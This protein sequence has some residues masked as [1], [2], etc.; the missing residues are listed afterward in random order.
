MNNWL[1]AIL[2][3]VFLVIVLIRL[4]TVPRKY[5]SRHCQGKLWKVN[6]PNTENE[7]IRSF[8]DCFIYGMAFFEKERLK[9]NPDDK[10]LDAYLSIY[11]GK[12]L[13][14][15]GDNLELESFMQ[16]LADEFPLGYSSIQDFW[17]ERDG[18]TLGE[19][20]HYV[21]AQKDV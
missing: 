8:L 4:G 7:K 20:F 2:F 18:V 13:K 10:V 15:K 17:N 12:N 1:I 16:A 9:F 3:I 11:D 14:F 6:F 21:T 5:S 19:M